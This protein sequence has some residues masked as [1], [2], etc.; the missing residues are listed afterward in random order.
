MET[1]QKSRTSALLLHPS[2]RW[3]ASDLPKAIQANYSHNSQSGVATSVTNST[4]S[5]AAP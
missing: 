2:D 1:P 3:E 5:C 4:G